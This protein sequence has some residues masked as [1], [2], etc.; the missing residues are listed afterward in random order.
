MVGALG[1]GG[2]GC[3]GD[4]VF[5]SFVG[6][7]RRQGS[8]NRESVGLFIVLNID[9]FR[10]MYINRSPSKAPDINLFFN[11]GMQILSEWWVMH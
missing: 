9:S 7:L 2:G 8:Q 11:R 4:G 1:G 6:G 3:N 10:I 5:H